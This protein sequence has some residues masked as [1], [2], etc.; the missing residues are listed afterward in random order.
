MTNNVTYILPSTLKF[1]DY[2]RRIDFCLKR[3]FTVQ[4]RRLVKRLNVWWD[5][6]AKVLDWEYERTTRSNSSVAIMTVSV[7]PRGPREVVTVCDE[8]AGVSQRKGDGREFNNTGEMRWSETSWLYSLGSTDRP[9]ITP[10]RSADEAWAPAR[11]GKVQTDRRRRA[12]RG[13]VG[14][15][16]W[17]GWLTLLGSSHHYKSC[18]NGALEVI[19][20]IFCLFLVP[21]CISLYLC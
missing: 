2:C 11:E 16:R 4:W 7:V 3:A 10:G 8:G 19:V 9:S 1:I 5:N 17:Y 20:F 12:G 21:L 13:E 6:E 18:H 14:R 15:G